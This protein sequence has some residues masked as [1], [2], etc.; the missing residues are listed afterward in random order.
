MDK[1]SKIGVARILYKEIVAGDLRKIEALSN[2]SPTGGGARDFR[3]GSFSKIS[4]AVL[5]M[6]PE[7]VVEKRKRSGTVV[8][9]EILK[10]TFY[11]SKPITGEEISKSSYF[12]PPTD[13]RPSEGRITRVND[14][15]CFDKSLIPEL[16]ERT[17]VLL[18]FVQNMDNKVW[19][20]FVSDFDLQ[21][22]GKWH[23]I[24]ADELLGCMHAERPEGKAVIGYK[25]FILE[26]Q[27]CNGKYH[28]SKK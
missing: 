25:D 14:Y 27:Y 19:P 1:N 26:E 5:N 28:F 17:R 22:K 6:F 10:G 23:P 2:D 15:P 12:E 16:N 7:R 4:K 20:Y 24:V 3:F 21:Q 13:A 8:D 9:L 11:W 18:L